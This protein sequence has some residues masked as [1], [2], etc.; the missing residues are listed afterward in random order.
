MAIGIIGMGYVGTALKEGF[1]D[2]YKIETY[3][4]D[5]SL[6]S[7]NSI[8]T[9]ISKVEVIFLCVPTPMDRNGSCDLSIVENIIDEINSLIKDQSNK[10]III[11]STVPPGTTE[12][13]NNK[14]QNFNII[15]NPEFLTEANFI[16]D[17]KNQNR[18]I[19]G[20]SKSVTSQIQKLYVKIFTK[21]KIV[22][23]DSTYAEMVKYFSN[24]FLAT[25]VSFANE[26]KMICDKLDIDYSKVVEY[27]TYDNRL[28]DSHW[29]V[30]GPDG[31]LGF[32][33]SCFPKDINA[34][35]SI[36]S[37]LGVDPILL[38]SVWDTNLKVRPEKD[39]EKLKGR[40]IS[41]DKD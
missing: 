12:S 36:A 21:A 41:N 11:K 31:K 32:G 22:E 37:K 29:S 34:L 38:K 3:D 40:A 6:S 16:E 35:I 10:I 23:T 17:F 18:I 14:Y 5:S 4:L 8:K 24:T 25:K 33:G 30:P 1:K 9:L 19:L 26:M 15:F 28:G 27:A 20:G 13:L 2:Y 39:W 7:C